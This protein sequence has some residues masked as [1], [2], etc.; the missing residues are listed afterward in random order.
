MSSPQAPTAFALD[1]SHTH[2][3]VTEAYLDLCKAR[4]RWEDEQMRARY[5]GLP[6]GEAQPDLASI[7]PAPKTVSLEFVR[8]PSGAFAPTPASQKAIADMQ[9]S[10][11]P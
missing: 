6:F 7:L 10:A 4:Q 8:G 9:A 2:G 1:V 3:T 5:Y 11:E